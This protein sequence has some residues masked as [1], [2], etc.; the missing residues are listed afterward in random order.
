[1]GTVFRQLTRRVPLLTAFVAF[2]ACGGGGETAAPRVVA[3]VDVSP[4]LLELA[5]GQ[6]S[7]LTA[8][9]KD[10]A[11]VS[12]SGRTTTW[13]SSNS[14]VVSVA[15]N[16]LVTAIS[17]GIASVTAMIDGNSGGAT[18]SVR[19]PV[20]AVVVTPT[21]A[22]LILGGA[23]LQLTAVTRSA[24]GAALSGRT[25][26]WLSNNPAVATVS[27]TGVVTG[28]AAGSATIAATSEGISGSATVQVSLNPC[29]VIRAVAVGQT[30]SGTL[31]TS[32]CKLG[33]N[34]VAQRYEFTL[35]VPTKIEITMSSS[36]VDSYLYLTDPA[37]N[38]IDEDDDGGTGID[39]RIL[40]TV[41]AGRYFVIVNTY[42]PNTFGAYQLTVR[43]AP[44]ACVTGRSTAV[45]STTDASLSTSSCLQRDESFED[46]YDII[47]GARTTMTVNMTSTALD[48]LLIVVDE[49]ERVIMQDDDGGA[50]LNASLEVLLEPGR[51][52]ILARGQPGQ[53][54]AYRLAVAP[55]I[56]PCAVTRTTGVGQVASGTFSAGDC[57]LSEG[58]GPNR[59][60][61]RFALTLGATTA[62]QLDMTSGVV[63]AY[64]IV[65][66]AQT[67]VVV[68]E[69]DDASGSTTNARVLVS[70][71]SGQYIVNAT[72]FDAG[73]VGPYQLS[74]SGIA[75][76]G[77][78]ITASPPILALQAGQS[79][80]AFSTVTGSANIAVAWQ[81]SAPSIASVTG[82]GL[83]RAIIP[84]SA[85]ITATSQADPSRFAT[86]AVT[87]G[88]TSGA[89]NLDIA[90]L[91]LVQ[92]VQQLDGRV[93][94]VADRGAVARV[95]L[96]GN[97][98]G[99]AAATVRVRILQGATVLGTFTATATPTLTVDEA[100]CS[101]N[102]V[103]PSS[104]IRTGI[105][106][107][108]DV[109][110]DNTVAEANEADNSYPLS[111][112]ALA[113]PVVTVPPFTI[114]LIPVQQNR[115]GPLA[116][117]AASLFDMLRSIM[118]MSTI[119]AVVRQP[120]VIDYVIG[121][122]SFD[123][124]IRLVRDVEI[125]RQTEGGAAYYYGLVRTRG[126]SGV[127]GLANGIPARSAIGVDEGSD[128]GAAE[129]KLTFAHEMGHTLSLRHSPCG[130]AAG[131]EPTYPFPDGS[132]G[133]YGMDTFNGNAIKLPN[134]KDV[135]TYCPN[136]WISA[137]NFR[138]VMDFRQANPNGAGLLAPTNVLMVSGGITRGVLTVDPA[139]SVKAAPAI[140]APSGR[141]VI[142]GFAAD[143][144]VLFARR[145]SPYRLDDADA[146][147]FVVAVPVSESVQAQVARLAVR[148]IR[149]TGAIARGTSRRVPSTTV[150]GAAI[151]V[152]R[153]PGAK[154]EITWSPSRLPAVMVRDR[155]SGEVLAIMRNGT[156]E[157]SQFGD[158]DRVELLLSDGVKSSR[159]AIDPITGAIRR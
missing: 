14:A 141:F 50:G 72:T 155:I 148:E 20:S 55:A 157:L 3:T 36:A 46:R 19:T 132:T 73:E 4:T 35:A 154:L 45:P 37:L 113:L 114:R 91:Y 142:E 106:V 87:V 126:T 122:Q 68:A 151:A 69:N 96:R 44:A 131:P 38:V 152:V 129:A 97:R 58:G 31:V 98:T 108:A 39:A 28:I 79:Q 145:F 43:P 119:N 102:I 134:A 149:G 10:A 117:G 150:G 65:Q 6:T 23:P 103:I 61:H 16:G 49:A 94:L 99:L 109:D 136:Q 92:A 123:D 71:P 80:Q 112:I 51:Y 138:K 27:S 84:G 116:A 57:A 101:A 147:A 9:A 115:N 29:N 5:P 17:D 146:E 30:L 22:E 93:P 64:L 100:C 21:T 127:L 59:Y 144:R 53:S 40:R 67:G 85:T 120:L 104:A 34:T 8:T 86:V 156:L 18:A 66:N 159:V 74:V 56:D 118:P 47:L 105:S 63:D 95:F 81:S 42:D 140:D 2:T 12:I 77:V 133:V 89:T 83:I 110:P 139:F 24:A 75:P 107:L 26:A 25:V 41:P 128:F 15:A 82:T 32:D 111:G 137:F 11:G 143:D 1:M 76:S 124:W 70:L 125:V 88:T 130:G 153:V 7:P 90:A 60:F 48:P 135:M 158:P 13:L 52:T 121:S 33:D 62:L 54:G 78:T